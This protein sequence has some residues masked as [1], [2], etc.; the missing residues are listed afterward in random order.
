MA[1]GMAVINT[2]VLYAAPD[3]LRGRAAGAVTFFR[4]IGAVMVTALIS[5]LLFALAPGPPGL[6]AG[7]IL[8]GE[9]AVDP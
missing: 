1:P 9:A 3:G 4:S 8:S 2:I 6:D 7:A 5:A